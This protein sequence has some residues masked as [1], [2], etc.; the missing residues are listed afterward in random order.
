MFS[1]GSLK[2]KMFLGEIGIDH[3]FLKILMKNKILNSLGIINQHNNSWLDFKEVVI[4]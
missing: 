3:K 4:I 1:A 2:T